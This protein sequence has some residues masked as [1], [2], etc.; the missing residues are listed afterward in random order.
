M[1]ALMR[2]QA[3]DQS[4]LVVVCDRCGH[5]VGTTELGMTD[6]R[7]LWQILQ[8]TGWGGPERPLGP[9]FC[10]ACTPTPR[11]GGTTIETP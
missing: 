1:T 11:S 3:A 7:L 9:H 2:S 5:A 8:Q 6:F 4:A 10:P